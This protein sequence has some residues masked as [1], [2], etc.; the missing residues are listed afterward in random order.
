[1]AA[2]FVISGS[3]TWNGRAWPGHQSALQTSTGT[4]VHKL[5][6]CCQ[7]GNER[8]AQEGGGGFGQS[9]ASCVDWPR[10]GQLSGLNA[11][12]AVGFPVITLLAS[13]WNSE[14]QGF[15][16]RI[17]MDQSQSTKIVRIC[18][19]HGHFQGKTIASNSLNWPCHDSTSVS[20]TAKISL[21]R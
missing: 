15:R 17:I 1:M 21:N 9:N 12:T 11:P 5:V 16:T 19:E 18:S 6:H 7:L 4:Q 10:L 8:T 20:L 14:S 3:G 2:I 13:F